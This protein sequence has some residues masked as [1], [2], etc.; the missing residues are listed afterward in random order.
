MKSDSE[1]K[2]HVEQAL[3]SDRRFDAADISVAVQRGV[4]TLSGS[5]RSQLE[6]YQAEGAARRIWGVIGL[7]NEIKMKP[8]NKAE[9]SAPEPM[10]AAPGLVRR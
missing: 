4:V 1:I 6:R 9:R 3:Q 2:Y 8:A 7:V 10:C 5:A